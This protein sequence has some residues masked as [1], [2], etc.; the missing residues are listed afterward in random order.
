M[1][2]REQDYDNLLVGDG[3]YEEKGWNA[4]VA[5]NPSIRRMRLVFIGSSGGTPDGF[6]CLKRPFMPSELYNVL[7][8]SYPLNPE[9]IMSNIAPSPDTDRRIF[10][11]SKFD[12]NVSF[13]DEQGRPITYLKARDISLGGLF[14][15]GSVPLQVGALAFLSF[16]LDGRKVSVTG[17]VVRKPSGG[18]G[19]R[20]LGLSKDAQEL[21]ER[22]SKTD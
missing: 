3:I 18:L 5:R 6:V 22:H 19:I 13:D 12:T 17:Q 14:L 11:R 16:E 21:I 9:E 1:L 20:F 8:M 2:L 10:E 15:E 7:G 4:L